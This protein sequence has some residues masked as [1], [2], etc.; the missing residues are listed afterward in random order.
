MKPQLPAQR[1]LTSFI[2]L[3]FVS[4]YSTAGNISFLHL[5]HGDSVT[6]L[7]DDN[8]SYT[9]TIERINNISESSLVLFLS[10]QDQPDCFLVVRSVHQ[11]ILGTCQ[12][13]GTI[14]HVEMLYDKEKNQ[15]LLKRET[16]T[17]KLLL[18]ERKSLPSF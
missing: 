7:L 1:I 16:E 18:S 15:L 3:L 13:N 4:F 8:E 17:G 2:V 5:N 12:M 14:K 6:L 11:T 9:A 10:I